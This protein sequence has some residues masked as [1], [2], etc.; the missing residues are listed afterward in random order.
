MNVNDSSSC[1]LQL[2]ED[3]PLTS[4]DKRCL[5]FIPQKRSLVYSLCLS[6]SR[7]SS[8]TNQDDVNGAVH[9]MV[10]KAVENLPCQK[11]FFTS[12]TLNLLSKTE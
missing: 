9:F 2:T 11:F 5:S 12:L 1:F 8:M 10:V 7:L 3:V 6:V 4:N